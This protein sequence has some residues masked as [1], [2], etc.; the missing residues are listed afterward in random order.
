MTLTFKRMTW[1]SVCLSVVLLYQAE[2][3]LLNHNQKYGITIA[4]LR[5][6]SAYL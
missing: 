6:G 5:N 2:Y 3:V 1:N 4:Y